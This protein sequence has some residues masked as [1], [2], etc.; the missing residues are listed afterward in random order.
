MDLPLYKAEFTTPPTKATPSPIC[1]ILLN[2]CAADI[3]PINQ[4]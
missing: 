2:N 1:P 3:A 4:T